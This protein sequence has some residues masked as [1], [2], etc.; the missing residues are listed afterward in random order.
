MNNI[1]MKIRTIIERHMPSPG[2]EVIIG[3][4]TDLV[5]DL[6][7]DSIS[8]FSLLLDLEQEFGISI[9][10]FEIESLVFKNIIKMVKDKMQK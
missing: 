5:E 8:F 1:E 6:G 3:D 7:F 10:C 4:D 9:L 2:I